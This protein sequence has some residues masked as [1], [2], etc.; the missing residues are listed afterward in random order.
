MKAEQ[1][2]LNAE[3]NVTL[4]AY[5]QDVKGEWS[6]AQ[7]PAVLVLP[8]GG[9]AMCSDREA[10]PVALAFLKAGYQAF[11][12]RY[13]VTS[14]GLWPLPLEDYEQAMSLMEE[15]ADEWHLAKD[16]VA[17][18]GFSAGG[19]LAACAA[20]MAQ[21]RPAAAVLGY[22]AIQKDIL[23]LCQPGLPLPAEH[24]DH[25]T[26]PCFLVACRDDSTVP[27]QH[28]LAFQMAL[29]EKGIR[30]ESHIYSYGDHGFS[31]GDS[32]QQNQ[33]LCPRV[34]DWTANCIGWLKEVLGDFTAQGLAK[35]LYG[36][37]VNGNAK[38]Y[39]S[40]ECT[41]EH[42]WKQGERTAEVMR[43]I[44]ELIA[45]A[46]Q[47]RGVSEQGMRFMLRNYTLQGLMQMCNLPAEMIG[48]L[49]VMLSKIENDA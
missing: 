48:T 43:P 32:Y 11:V 10:D 15:K 6:F 31:T 27:I 49:D 2:V 38:P 24:I 20:T 17:V 46:A 5:L 1:I 25:K 41:L 39:L 35:P 21:H 19:H 18:I 45:K 13:T 3:R 9:Y 34:P 47:E 37:T 22:P 14:K 33:P 7:R 4:T 23:D 44:D 26:P 12:L 8:G 30:F 40:V 36:A 42:L 28:S 29:A 16:K